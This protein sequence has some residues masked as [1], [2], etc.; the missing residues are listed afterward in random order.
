MS[1]SVKPVA[2]SMRDIKA[3][4]RESIKAA[5]KV[6]EDTRDNIKNDETWKTIRD[7]KQ[8]HAKEL[9]KLTTQ[10]TKDLHAEKDVG[11]QKQFILAHQKVLEG[12]VYKQD[13]E[14]NAKLKG[15]ED[16]IIKLNADLAN[17]GD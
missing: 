17:V 13:D 2:P 8:A 10:L 3:Q 9:E 1:Q 4:L 12:G 14:Y 15:Y 7:A 6:A 11:R 5:I 16:E